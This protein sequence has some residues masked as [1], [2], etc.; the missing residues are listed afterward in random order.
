MSIIL[1]RILTSHF[2]SFQKIDTILIGL[3]LFILSAQSANGLIFPNGFPTITFGDSNPEPEPESN[4]EESRYEY[5]RPEPKPEPRPEPEPEP[6]PFVWEKPV[7]TSIKTPSTG[8]ALKFDLP[9]IKFQMP[10][11]RLPGVSLKA[12]IRNP[13]MIFK[14]LPTH[15]QLP[16]INFESGLSVSGA[17]GGHHKPSHHNY[18][19]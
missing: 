15:F 13:P 4:H 18:D 2:C 11:L 3:V 14:L 12:T 17:S 10:A 8:L 6:K 16:R 1:K 19:D 9:S 7:P 5:S